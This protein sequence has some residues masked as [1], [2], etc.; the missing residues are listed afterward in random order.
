M[1]KDEKDIAEIAAAGLGVFVVWKLI[2]FLFGIAILFAAIYFGVHYLVGWHRAIPAGQ[3]IFEDMRRLL[4][5]GTNY[6]KGM[7]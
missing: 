7:H 2:K 6:I 5:Q 1:N 3:V 4:I